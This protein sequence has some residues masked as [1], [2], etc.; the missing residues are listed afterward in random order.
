M[1]VALS[2]FTA[3]LLSAALAQGELRLY[4]WTGY[5]S[6]ELL[7]KFEA[8]TGIR[9]SLDTYDSNETLLAKLK[10]GATGYDIVVPSHNFVQ[11]FVSEG[12]L[13]PIHASE[14]ANYS[15]IDE[16]WRNPDWDPGNVYTVPW[17]WGT[18]SFAVDTA[19]Y[20]GD[21]DTYEVLFN[22]PEVF[23]GRIGMFDSWDE[24]LPMALRYTGSEICTTDPEA[25]RRALEV[26]EAQEPYVKVYTSEGI[27]ENMI[28]GETAMNTYWNGATMRVRAER[29]TVRYAYPVEGVS[30]W[31]DNLALARGAPNK[32]AALTFINWFLE[33]ENAALQSNFAR[34]ANAVSGAEA[35]M[36]EPLRTAPE[37][38]PPEGANIIFSPTCP[39]E[40][41]R[42][43]DRVWTRLKQ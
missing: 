30:G 36:D 19:L 12:L 32:E 25:F 11:I 16:R 35:F 34:Y 9:V 23:R 14:M 31:M 42:L 4:N 10:S 41:I 13:E 38:V 39:E 1:K 6:Q 26:L 5:T 33:P 29:P 27:L 17:Q 37:I 22:P 21:I 18:T 20:D 28:A 15:N 3:L 40:Y 7:Q 43:A 8:E 2:L 24:V